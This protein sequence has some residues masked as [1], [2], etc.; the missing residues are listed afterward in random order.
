M[1]FKAKMGEFLNDV[2]SSMPAFTLSPSKP[3]KHEGRDVKDE[4]MKIKLLEAWNNLRYDLGSGAPLKKDIPIWILGKCYHARASLP[5]T[6]DDDEEDVPDFEDAPIHAKA[7]FMDFA[8][9][10]WFTYRKQFPAI[11]GTDITSDT[12]WG[13]MLRSAQM[14]LAQGLLLH[15][16]GRDWRWLQRQ[17]QHD[18]H[19]HRMILEWFVDSPT[20]QCPLSIHHLAEIGRKFG[21]VP[22]N[23]YGPNTVAYIVQEAVQRAKTNTPQLRE[24]AV[25]VA[26]DCTVY[27]GDVYALCDWKDESSQQDYNL[28]SELLT[29]EPRGRRPSVITDA[30]F[31]DSLST[32]SAS[33]HGS[34]GN[35]SESSEVSSFVI[36]AIPAEDLVM[37]QST[38]NAIPMTQL[39]YP[40]NGDIEVSLKPP[41]SSPKKRQEHR[42]DLR[43]GGTQKTVDEK[44]VQPKTRNGNTSEKNIGRSYS[45][46]SKNVSAT[47][48][49]DSLTQSMPEAYSDKTVQHGQMS[50]AKRDAM[51][52]SS[53]HVSVEK[54]PLLQKTDVTEQNA[55]TVRTNNGHTPHVTD[56]AIP[57]NSIYC[58]SRSYPTHG[59]CMAHERTDNGPNAEIFTNTENVHDL[60]VSPYTQ[61]VS[62]LDMDG[63]QSPPSHT[64][65]SNVEKNMV[66]NLHESSHQG[67]G[68][69]QVEHRD[70]TGRRQEAAALILVPVRL[71]ESVLNPV[72]IPH[73][74][75]MLS[76]VH[77]IG[78]IGGKPK[79]SLYFVGFQ[80]ENLLHLDP[81][82]CQTADKPTGFRKNLHN[83]HTMSIR[84]TSVRKVDPSCCLGFYCR[85]AKDFEV[86]KREAKQ[87]FS[88]SKFGTYPMYLVMDG[89]S[90]DH[91]PRSPTSQ[92]ELSKSKNSQEPHP[93][94]GIV[95][96][97]TA[98][99]QED[100]LIRERT[101]P[102]PPQSVS[103]ASAEGRE[104]GL[105][106]VSVLDVRKSPS[107]ESPRKAHAKTP[108]EELTA[109]LNRLLPDKSKFYPKFMRQKSSSPASKRKNLE[110][111]SS[112]E[113]EFE[114][115]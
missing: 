24:V 115:L 17:S 88:S 108:T 2:K 52:T 62:S 34:S 35:C 99:R 16:L 53:S 11:Q 26:Q 83:Y 56:I 107:S 30:D 6:S 100:Y 43:R 104:C 76:V 19:L 103:I 106:R 94:V 79:H 75:E 22:G 68:G 1:A 78:I 66:Q 113:H 65:N 55:F 81:H 105:E 25:Y 59:A 8:S 92:K 44:K 46:Q 80:D 84:K 61:R 15:F 72:Y 14:M 110:K 38:S 37:P 5:V 82:Y 45:V 3:V 54:P 91:Q 4:K 28:E 7:V 47:Q 102:G 27:S 49:V 98:H 51:F 58:H 85:T 86:F 39:F 36:P 31:Q 57:V 73:M 13:C 70:P 87:N 67:G 90:G 18:K 10:P 48:V 63:K 109:K 60:H 20:L 101:S 111:Q 29:K 64:E 21:N 114:L 69:A 77:S 71:G 40:M 41:K 89:C 42:D 32:S 97:S 33:S 96:G 74:Q 23:W 9:R 50:A 112:L 12:G 93:K 95:S